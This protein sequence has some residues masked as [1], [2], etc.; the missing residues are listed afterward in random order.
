MSAFVLDPAHINYLVN[1][2]I[3]YNRPF[4]SVRFAGEPVSS[5]NA[6]EV[7]R[8]L[9]WEN[10]A[11]VTALYGERDNLPGPI[12]TPKPADFRWRPT[13]SAGAAGVDAVKVLKAIACYEYQSCEH[14][15]WKD[16]AAHDFCDRLRHAT[17]NR[18]PGYDDAPWEIAAPRPVA[19]VIVEQT[20]DRFALDETDILNGGHWR[21]CEHAI[22]DCEALPVD[23]CIG[24]WAPITLL[25]QTCPG[26][27]ASL[28]PDDTIEDVLRAPYPAVVGN[29]RAKT[30][31]E[32][33]A[34]IRKML[35]G[36]GLKGI[37]VTAPTWAT[38]A[39]TRPTTTTTASTSPSHQPGADR[40]GRRHPPERSQSHGL[41]RR[42]PRDGH[43]DR[44]SG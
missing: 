36:L 18:L 44:G 10:I 5:T 1:A 22:N 23:R 21:A 20:R 17:I 33:A 16:S 41:R 19:P 29:I 7:G 4:Q 14:P 35:R 40:P 24:C 6:T 43:H 25:H 26:C 13:G 9:L 30:R 42:R 32:I 34:D 39:T 27:G 38:A 12:P 3:A 37:S 11:S 28:R 31:K 15:G 2:A 8:R